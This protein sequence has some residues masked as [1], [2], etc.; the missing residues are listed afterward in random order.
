[1]HDKYI[2]VCTVTCRLQRDCRT[3]PLPH[4]GIVLPN[5]VEDG[6]LDVGPLC[7]IGGSAHAGELVG[8][9]EDPLLSFHAKYL[10]LLVDSLADAPVHSLLV[11]LLP[12]CNGNLHQTV[13]PDCACAGQPHL[14][15]LLQL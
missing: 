9:H 4:V 8:G 6:D 5:H 12:G 14:K 3:D 1:M 11:Q 10:V 15:E 2:F 7:P 13:L